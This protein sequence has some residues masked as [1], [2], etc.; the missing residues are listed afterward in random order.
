MP[1]GTTFNCSEINRNRDS[2][3]AYFGFRAFFSRS[4]TPGVG[5]QHARAG[6]Q[7]ARAGFHRQ[8][9]RPVFGGIF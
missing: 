3:Q 2:D 1:A 6:S 4:E 5:S 7:H 9:L 8:F